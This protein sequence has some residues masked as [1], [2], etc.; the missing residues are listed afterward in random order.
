MAAR[1][2]R[3][4]SSGL[5]ARKLADALR[6]ERPVPLKAIRDARSAQ[7]G[8]QEKPD[9]GSPGHPGRPAFPQPGTQ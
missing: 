3:K 8:A 1:G 5:D 7:A 2:R 4:W 6:I 9:A